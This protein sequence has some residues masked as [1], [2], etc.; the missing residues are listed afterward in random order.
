MTSGNI[1]YD[2]GGYAFKASVVHG[3]NGDSFHGGV[4]RN[5]GPLALGGGARF[6][7]DHWDPTW[8]FG[9]GG[10]VALDVGFYGTH[11]NLQD[12]Q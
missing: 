10:R 1:G 3:F 11:A 9:V 4:E 5:F 7:R 8:G 12:Q 2:G 6:S